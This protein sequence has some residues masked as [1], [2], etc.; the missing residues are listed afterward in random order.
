MESSS[1]WASGRYFEFPFNLKYKDAVPCRGTRNPLKAIPLFQSARDS[2]T[3]D[4]SDR[5]FDASVPPLASP[6]IVDIGRIRELVSQ[7]NSLRRKPPR[8]SL[9]PPEIATPC[10]CLPSLRMHF[11]EKGRETRHVVEYWNEIFLRER[12]WRDA[13]IRISL[14]MC[15]LRGM[16]CSLPWDQISDPS[17][18]AFVIDKK[19]LKARPRIKSVIEIVIVTTRRT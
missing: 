10:S 9:A 4:S 19:M 14:N 11:R 16:M 12:R 3:L 18:I 17:A 1:L 13:H 7:R 2:C 6:L 5:T 15:P 8:R